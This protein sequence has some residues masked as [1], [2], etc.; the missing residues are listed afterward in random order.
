MDISFHGIPIAQ[1]MFNLLIY[2]YLIDRY[3]IELFVEIGV[4]NGGLA[5]VIIH[6]CRLPTWRNLHY[7]GVQLIEDEVMPQVKKLVAETAA[8]HGNVSI[9]YGD[10]FKQPTISL[11]TGRMNAAGRTLVLC[12]GGDK[13]QE[14]NLYLPHLKPDDLIIAHDYGPNEEWDRVEAD[15]LDRHDCVLL[16]PELIKPAGNLAFIKRRSNDG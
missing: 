7:L 4:M 11:I 5:N 8:N 9:H 15:I 10:A 1:T 6:R 2:L 13:P 16:E 3:R 14:L 12:D